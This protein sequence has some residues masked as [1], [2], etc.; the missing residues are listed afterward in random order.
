MCFTEQY[1]TTKGLEIHTN[2]SSYKYTTTNLLVYMHDFL[3]K[4]TR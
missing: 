1:A 4:L 3:V 2:I